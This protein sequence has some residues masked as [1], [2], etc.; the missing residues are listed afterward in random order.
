VPGYKVKDPPGGG[1]APQTARSG[2]RR[3]QPLDPRSTKLFDGRDELLLGS[4]GAED[5]V[6]EPTDPA[7]VVSEAKQDE[8]RAV[9]ADVSG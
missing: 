4:A 5:C 1:V 9:A 7:V 8:A 3:G 6:R 2:P